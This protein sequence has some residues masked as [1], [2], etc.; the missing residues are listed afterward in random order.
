MNLSENFVIVAVSTLITVTNFSTAF[1]SDAIEFCTLLFTVEISRN[2]AS[3][4]ISSFEG[5]YLYKVL[6]LIPSSLDIS[7][8]VIL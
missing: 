7:S 5:K 3:S 6:L 2:I 4:S 8:I 1:S